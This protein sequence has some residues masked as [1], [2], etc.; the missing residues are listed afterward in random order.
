LPIVACL[1]IAIAT[2][3]NTCHIAYSMHVTVYS[4]ESFEKLGNILEMFQYLEI[5]NTVVNCSG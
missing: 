1:S 3:L 5:C 4:Y 2:V